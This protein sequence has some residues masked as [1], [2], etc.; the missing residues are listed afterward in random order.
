MADN[1]RKS[2]VFKNRNIHVI[3]NDL[4]LNIFKPIDKKQARQS[5]GLPEDRLLALF[6]AMSSTEN[7]GK[8]FDLL[9]AGLNQLSKDWRNTVD[10]VVFGSTGS[11]PIKDS[12]FITHFLGDIYDDK[13]LVELYLS[14]DVMI[15]PSRQDN[16][17]NIVSESLACGTPVVAFDIGGIPEMIEHEVSGYL[18]KAFD[19][20]DLA[21]GAEFVLKQQQLNDYM[22]RAARKMATDKFFDQ[23]MSLKYISLYEAIRKSDRD[24]IARS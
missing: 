2:T 7:T 21:S 23:E 13:K 24:N 22:S 19:T 14:V 6:G 16:L 8:G 12:G 1:A 4:D 3:H 10:L 11:S 15:V 9:V 18:A 20:D 17:P 5:L